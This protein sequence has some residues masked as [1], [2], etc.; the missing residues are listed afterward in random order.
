M[1]GLRD[2]V[3][4]LIGYILSI[5]YLLFLYIVATSIITVIE[6]IFNSIFALRADIPSIFL[7]VKA[8]LNTV[9]LLI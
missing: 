7:T 2:I 6:A 1:A 3:S 9:S 4:G 8:L 5:F